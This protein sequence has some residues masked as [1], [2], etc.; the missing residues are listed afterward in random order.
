MTAP[1]WRASEQWLREVDLADKLFKNV[2]LGDDAELAR[3][4]AV[5]E[6]SS[7]ES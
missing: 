3:K 4:I 2:G 6:R 1:P 5:G 7:T